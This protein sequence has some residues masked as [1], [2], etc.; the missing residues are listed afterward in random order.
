MQELG[1]N[2]ECPEETNVWVCECCALIVNNGDDSGCR[3]YY[4]HTHPTCN[5]NVTC[6]D[7]NNFRTTGYYGE[8][9]DGCGELIFGT[10]YAAN[11]QTN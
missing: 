3:D 5:N 4:E 8:N 2:S 9:C 10:M 1:T 6:V 7:S 11:Q